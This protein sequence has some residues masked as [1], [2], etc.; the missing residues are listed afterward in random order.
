VSAISKGTKLYRVAMNNGKQPR[1][2]ESALC[3]QPLCP[4]NRMRAGMA[5]RVKQLCA[6]AE[7]D[8]RL[9][10]I[11]FVEEQLV[12]LVCCGTNV[13]CIVC[14]A[15]LALSAKLAEAVL[16]EVVDQAPA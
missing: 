11:G 12:K 1:S 3:G 4:L 8:Q 10:E 6:S 13:I 7:V 16:V 14:N 5:G 2:F 9:R 15:R